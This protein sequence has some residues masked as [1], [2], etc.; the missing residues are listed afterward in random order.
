MLVTV[1]IL[2]NFGIKFVNMR[3]E[4]GTKITYLQKHISVGHIFKNFNNEIWFSL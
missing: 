1:I 2:I 3:T 4:L